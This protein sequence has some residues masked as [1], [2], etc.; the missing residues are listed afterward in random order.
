MST[1]SAFRG[2]LV[3]EV[4]HILRDWQTLLILVGMPLVQ[5]VL[6][7]YAVRSDVRGINLAI[8]EPQP[9]AAKGK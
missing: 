6:F 9:D 8:V 1:P 3:K 2:F 7:G 5:V 4:R